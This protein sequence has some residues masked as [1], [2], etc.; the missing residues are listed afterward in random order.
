MTSCFDVI[1]RHLQVGR[2]GLVCKQFE[3]RTLATLH[4][5]PEE[6]LNNGDKSNSG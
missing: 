4:P 5:A 3:R 6:T 2:A 1:Y